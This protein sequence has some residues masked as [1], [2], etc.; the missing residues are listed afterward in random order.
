MCCI[1]F[2]GVRGGVVADCF[3]DSGYSY[4]Y[5]VGDVMFSTYGY[6]AR[7]SYSE[8]CTLRGNTFYNNYYGVSLAWSSSCSLVDN[9]VSLSWIGIEV[10]D[11]TGCVLDRNDLYSNRYGA[12]LTRADSSTIANQTMIGL[13]SGLGELGG[14]ALSECRGCE[15]HHNTFFGSGLSIELPTPL[16]P[17][18]L[19]EHWNH[20][21]TGNMVNGKP[22]GYFWNY[23]N[24]V[25]D[26]ASNGQVILAGCRNVTVHHAIVSNSS[27]AVQ[28][29]H[30]VNVTL[31]DSAISNDTV[32]GVSLLF[33]EGCSVLNCTITGNF[34]GIYP[35]HVKDV[36]VASNVLFGNWR[37]V[38][39]WYVNSSCFCNN[40]IR[41][42]HCGIY[43]EHGL[44]CSIENNLIAGCQQ[45]I[46]L[47]FSKH[48][49]IVGNGVF[50]SS[51][52]GIR[53]T[54]D[55]QYNDVYYNS[56]G[57]NALNGEDRGSSNTWDDGISRGN[58]LE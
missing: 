10:T 17:P 38:F 30:C 26:A 16:G 33:C 39:A 48:C 19:L 25:I 8:N 58:R 49:Q 57:W 12:M 29:G 35:Y 44:F 1:E 34:A 54:A 27:A 32:R 24:T 51:Q 36:R 13:G 20:S 23:S 14:V 3:M 4:W 40:S 2:E 52:V 22:L 46:D 7:A 37:S 18:S 41:N 53:L 5:A 21:V 11:S 56:V 28:L 50:N 31:A 47:W 9:G 43:L 55:S 15:V 45:G 6:G 42:A